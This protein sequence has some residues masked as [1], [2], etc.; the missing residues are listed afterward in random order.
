MRNLHS[1]PRAATG[2]TLLLIAVSFPLSAA[3]TAADVFASCAYAP[4]L[5]SATS[6]REPLAKIEVGSGNGIF[7]RLKRQVP[8]A[9]TTEFRAYIYVF[10]DPADPA[11][12]VFPR[13]G[14]G[15]NN[16]VSKDSPF[17]GSIDLD[18]FDGV[19]VM[20]AVSPIPIPNVEKLSAD[21]IRS[22]FRMRNHCRTFILNETRL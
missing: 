22:Y 2:F 20:V 7:D 21:E 18:S 17:K 5:P 13:V 12:L 16:Q 9:V 1:F 15:D 19:T 10:Q 11:V 14:R 6:T 3:D 8:I 4:I